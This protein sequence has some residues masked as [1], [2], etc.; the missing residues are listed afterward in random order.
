MNTSSLKTFAQQARQNLL[1]GVTQRLNFWGYDNK[2]NLTDEPIFV[3][4]GMLL[5]EEAFDEPGAEP[6]WKALQRAIREH[7]FQHVVEEAAYTWFNRLMAIRIL[8]KNDFDF[9]QLEYES[10]MKVPV[11]LRRARAGNYSFLRREEGE[12]LRK[13]LTDYDKEY[14]AFSILISGYC[15][16][17][18][19]LGSV[20]GRINDYTGLLLPSNI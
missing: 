12:S 5:R 20:F 11:I 7:G 18:K 3:P 16:H 8:A 2:G 15:R 1:S 14:Q 13:V 10:G 9:P 6:K 4:G 19:L 17:H